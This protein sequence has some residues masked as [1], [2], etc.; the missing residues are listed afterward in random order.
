MT[1]IEA[2]GWHDEQTDELFASLLGRS[3]PTVKDDEEEENV[4][5]EVRAGGEVG[6]LRIFG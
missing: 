3:F 6:Q 4:A 2:N 1:P 5:E